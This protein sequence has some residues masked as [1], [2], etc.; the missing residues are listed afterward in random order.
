MK[1]VGILLPNPKYL[2]IILFS[3][4]FL[5]SCSIKKG[6]TLRPDG[7]KQENIIT[8]ENG[9]IKA[10]FV[11]NIEAG[12]LHRAGYNG[13]AELY[14]SKEDSNIFVPFYAGFNLEHIFGGDSLAELFEPRKHPMMLFRKSDNEVLLYQ[15]S[16]P[17]SGI[18]TL[19]EFKVTNPDYIDITFHCI[20][21]NKHFF[22]HGYAGLFWASYINKPEDKKIYFIGIEEKKSDTTWIA[23]YSEEHGLNSTHRS[24]KD[25]YNFFFAEN[26]NAKLANH[27]SV[28]RYVLPFYFGRFRKMVLAYFFESDEIIRF[29][30]SP[31]GG[32]D[33]NP[34][35][36]FQYIIPSPKIG[37]EYSFKARMIYRPFISKKDLCDEYE[38]WKAK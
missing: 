20:L 34:A 26:F 11:D 3:F 38:N 21:H 9:N 8:I 4:L 30:Q 10:M 25:D 14:H 23:A 15:E 29:S 5:I 2:L 12:L 28:Y 13:V 35:W 17:L 16:T 27:Y 36:D 1:D 37:Q 31:T 18:E 32:G 19:T 6:N 7:L 24:I 22:Q 33:D